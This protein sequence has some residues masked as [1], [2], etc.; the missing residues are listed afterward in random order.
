MS[1]SLDTAGARTRR[2]LA[3]LAGVPLG[4]ALQMQQPV[5]WPVANYAAVLCVAG[6]LAL[7]AWRR[8]WS[9][10]VAIAVSTGLMWGATGLRAVW[11]D[12]GGLSTSVEE[13]DVVVEGWIAGLPRHG[14]TGVQFEWHT[15]RAWVNGEP[16][17]M[18]RSVRLSWRSSGPASDAVR[19]LRPG[20]RWRLTV[21]VYRPHGLS[22]P[23][24]FDSELW[25]WEQGLHAS[26]TVRVGPRVAPPVWLE[27]T[28][29]YP[30]A[31]A[32]YDARARLSNAVGGSPG[33]GVLLALLTGD[34]G[35]I[36]PAQWD[37]FRV[38]GVTHLV[39]VSGMHITFFSWLAMAAMGLGWRQAG[40]RWP[41]L[42]LAVPTPV[43]AA[44][45]GALLGLAYAVFSGWAVPAQRA[46]LMMLTLVA[47]RLSGRRWPWPFLWLMVMAVVLM[48]DPW[49]ILRAGFWLSFVAVAI[50]FASG[51]PWEHRQKGW[52]DHAREMVRTQSRVTL[53]LAPLTLMW[54]GEFS[55]V[56]LL[57]NLLAIP[58][59]TLVVTP[60]A[61]GG[62]LWPMLWT[63]G[64][65]TADVLLWWL[66]FLGQWSWA[67][68][69]RPEAQWWLALTAAIGGCL[70][71]TRVPA[72][73]RL[74]G[75]LLM[76]PA[77]AYSP[78]R[79][80]E[81]RYEWIA[82][83]VGQ[84]TAVIVRTRNH[85]LVYDTGPPMGSRAV[86]A[87][88]VL[89]PLL[90]RQGDRPDRVVISHSDLDHSSGMEALARAYP[91]ATW[92]LSFDAP[93]SLRP[94]SA[95][96]LAGEGW[97]WDGVPFRFLHPRPEDHARRLSPNAMSC[98]LLVGEPGSQLLLTGDITMAEETRLAL[99]HPG[100]RADVL[101][102]GHHGSKTSTGPVWLNTVRPQVVVIQAGHRNPFGHPAAEVL[103]RLETRQIPWVNT[104]TCGAVSGSS[105]EPGRVSCH[106]E[107][108][109]RYWHAPPV[110][111]ARP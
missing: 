4:A 73:V 3:C 64:A 105:A 55:V 71:V 22:N 76:W 54:F 50:L 45:G 110:S 7:V 10:F 90:R 38:T 14:E 48:I 86:S 11:H 102:A 60:L 91:G 18:P 34:Q 9:G 95:P 36:T 40:R 72:S 79:P 75:L 23:G 67:S 83:D 35:S 99:E 103:R 20:Q 62:V 108:T 52:W 13:R 16:I 68:V 104:A 111:A 100:L 65:W 12:R 78:S 43:A 63:L 8:G 69:S 49:A 93:P 81:G 74:W 46:A 21:R 44:A 85:T 77:L 28:W 56:G 2:A 59:V 6:L 80:A 26:G 37:V 42:L 19:A 17:E 25:M 24:G 51:G 87:E 94:A 92:H 106:R 29:R 5:L 27:D 89:I 41:G 109:R 98:V 47:L 33:Q 88:R 82:P 70:A 1:A 107:A 15:E 30:V 57:A 53:S 84:G 31:Q 96:C 39:V 61:I 101:F 66:E 58:W 97:T 32:R